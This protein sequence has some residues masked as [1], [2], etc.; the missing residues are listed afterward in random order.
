LGSDSL[1]NTSITPPF[2]SNQ[3]EQKTDRSKDK[4]IN[5]ATEEMDILKR[6][7]K[8]N[9]ELKSDA[10]IN[11]THDKRNKVCNLRVGLRL[12]LLD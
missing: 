11:K 12:L 5:I 9:T 6:Q 7:S 8:E 4:D 10:R 3:K 1:L 2:V